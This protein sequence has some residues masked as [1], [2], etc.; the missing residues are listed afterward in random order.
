MMFSSILISFSSANLALLS[1]H[2]GAKLYDR[3]NDIVKKMIFMMIVYGGLSGCLFYTLAPRV[4][5]YLVYT[6][7]EILADTIGYAQVM[8]LDIVVLSFDLSL[9]ILL[10]SLG[11][12][13]AV[14][15]SQAVGSIT[16]IFLDPILINGFHIVP[17][18]GVIG[19]A[20]ATVLSKIMSIAVLIIVIFRKYPWIK[21]GVSHRIDRWYIVTAMNVAIPLFVMV[22][23]NSLAFQ[24]QNRLINIFGIVAATAFSIGFL[25]FD[26][27]NTSLWGLTEGIAIMVGQNLGAGN[28]K[29]SR[30]IALKTS[31]FIFMAVALTSATIYV[32]KDWIASAFITGINVDAESMA[33]IYD[34]YDQFINMT[35]WTL[36][37]F[38]ITFSAMSVGRGSGHTLAPTV[39]NILRL[40]AIRL[41]LGYFLA[42]TLG[43]STMGIYTAFALSNIVGGIASIV[44]IYKGSWTKPII[45]EVIPKPI[46]VPRGTH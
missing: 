14:A 30:D 12:T 28:I 29:R 3:V 26:L 42:L 2:I 41:G 43:L 45:R 15:I 36:A 11:D 37:F 19:A 21:I 7:S 32:T 4:F 38:A 10:Q 9:V 40:W 6:P 31:A 1:Q 20:L 24:L 44:W 13:K 34:E 16:N 22:L 17:A 33:K 39:I 27:A 23:S 25:V 8:S 18:M 35:I 46:H 5:C